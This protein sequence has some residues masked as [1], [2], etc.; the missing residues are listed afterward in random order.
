MST[1]NLVYYFF[2]LTNRSITIIMARQPNFFVFTFVP[3]RKIVVNHDFLYENF[4]KNLYLDLSKITLSVLTTNCCCCWFLT[5]FYKMLTNF[6]KSNLIFLQFPV[7]TSRLILHRYCFSMRD[8][9]GIH[10][11]RLYWETIFVKTDV[12]TTKKVNLYVC[13]SV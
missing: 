10:I 5:C 7:N 9:I 2:S 3:H 13:L 12:R 11:T 8:G 6:L 4:V 1:K